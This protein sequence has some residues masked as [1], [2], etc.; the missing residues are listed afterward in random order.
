[1]VIAVVLCM[2]VN[3]GALSDPLITF[4]SLSDCL[5]TFRVIAASLFLSCVL[6]LARIYPEV[7]GFVLEFPVVARP[8]TSHGLPGP[9][10]PLVKRNFALFSAS[11][12]SNTSTIE[13]IASIPPEMI[14]LEV[15]MAKAFEAGDVQRF[16]SL[17]KA[18]GMNTKKSLRT[19]WPYFT[20]KFVEA[21]TPIQ[22][23]GALTGLAH[24]GMTSN[25]TEQIQL[26]SGLFTIVCRHD[27]PG[28]PLDTKEALEA[29]STMGFKASMAPD[30]KIEN[31]ILIVRRDMP[32]YTA[33]HVCQLMH[34]FD[35]WDDIPD[36]FQRSILL[37][38]R[39]LNNKVLT[40]EQY[41]NLIL[42]YGRLQM[43][44][45]SL[46][47]KDIQM[48]SEIAMKA[49]NL[50]KD[51]DEEGYNQ[52]VLVKLLTGLVG[53]GQTFSKMER[54]MQHNLELA[55]EMMYKHLDLQGFLNVVSA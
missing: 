26:M 30:A 40:A 14:P 50:L 13:S 27:N 45:V 21:L 49:F 43:E 24:F 3:S 42:S 31:F 39:A 10:V 8:T 36:S 53:M 41:A 52:R 44:L 11:I 5:M 28:L 38:T 16:L 48:I 33:D 51:F 19:V 29:L 22:A 25:T 35:H 55:C 12:D 47:L 54:S 32:F 2:C 23:L 15:D 18:L 20:P 4:E 46:E 17:F 9:I 7:D 1:M 6:L 37:K 34:L